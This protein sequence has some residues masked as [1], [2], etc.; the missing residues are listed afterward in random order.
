[1]QLT[2]LGCNGP[3][4][5]PGGA[6]S[7]YLL[8]QDAANILVDCG[9][10]CLA[11]LQRYCAI[12]ELDAVVLSHLH[13]DHIADVFLLRYALMN[14]K[15]KEIPL[16]MPGHPQ[17]VHALLADGQEFSTHSIEAK[18]VAQIGGFTIRFFP[19]SHPVPSF[20]MDIRAGGTRL[21]YSGDSRKHP[22]MAKFIQD[23]PYFLC[24]AAFLHEQKT[25]DQIPHMTALEAAQLA[26]AARVGKLMLTH[27]PPGANPRRWTRQACM[28]HADTIAV[29]QGK[30][31][32]I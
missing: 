26:E 30:C 14:L 29:E 5:P 23:A 7:G 4:A 16:Y 22:P 6:T 31:Y 25:N 1:M 27:F 9:S 11:Q 17:A 10:G 13:F 18:T 24:D 3:Y 19:G 28:V 21:C 15:R 12:E 2:V 32:T 20:A 8:Q